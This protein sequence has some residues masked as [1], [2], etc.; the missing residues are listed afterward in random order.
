MC[1]AFRK[2]VYSRCIP[3]IDSFDFLRSQIGVPS[4]VP[5]SASPESAPSVPWGSVSL[6]SFPVEGGRW[7]ARAGGGGKGNVPP[8][9][10]GNCTEECGWSVVIRRLV[11]QEKLSLRTNSVE[12]GPSWWKTEPPPPRAL[13]CWSALPKT[14]FCPFPLERFGAAGMD[15]LRS[16]EPDR[17]G[18]IPSD[19]QKGPNW[20]LG[21]S[22]LVWSRESQCFMLEI[23]LQFYIYYKQVNNNVN[24]LSNSPDPPAPRA[25]LESPRGGTR[26]QIDP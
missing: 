22:Q 23:S 5:S 13:R 14:T 10:R 20:R 1:G 7:Y 12:R 9:W 25:I 4:T 19:F 6:L 11:R 17:T 15:D 2:G 18:P 26:R 21:V 16:P 8:T 24:I 3:R